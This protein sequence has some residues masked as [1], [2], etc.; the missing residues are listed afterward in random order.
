[1][2]KDA[3]CYNHV[4]VKFVL[5]T[6]IGVLRGQYYLAYGTFFM[7]MVNYLNITVFV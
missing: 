6:V 5:V 1:M 4:Y 7:F 3:L 2:V